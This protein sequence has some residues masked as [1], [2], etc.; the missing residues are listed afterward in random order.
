MNEGKP[1]VYSIGGRA[2]DAERGLYWA[3][4][5]TRNSTKELVPFE[6]GKLGFYRYKMNNKS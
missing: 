3:P 2:N 6:G 4:Y 1:T 5:T